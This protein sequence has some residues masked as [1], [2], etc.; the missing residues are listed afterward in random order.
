MKKKRPIIVI[1]LQEQVQQ[2]ANK[3]LD[4]N[5]TRAID[6]LL[7]KALKSSKKGA[8]DAVV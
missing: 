8:N 5:F 2:Y 7:R 4:G 6:E 3:N 1:E